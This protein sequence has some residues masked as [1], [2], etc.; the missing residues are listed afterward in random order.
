M[1]KDLQ[2][3]FLDVKFSVQK[4]PKMRAEIIMVSWTG[5]GCEGECT[6]EA[7]KK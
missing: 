5:Y 4:M 6:P 3:A 1:K 2:R 7:V